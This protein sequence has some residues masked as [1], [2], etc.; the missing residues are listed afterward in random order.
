M[1]IVPPEFKTEDEKSEYLKKV[2]AQIE[3]QAGLNHPF[4]PYKIQACLI[5]TS[6][7]TGD[8]QRSNQ[9]IDQYDLTKKYQVQKV[10][11]DAPIE[12]STFKGRGRLEKEGRGL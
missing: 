1:K 6:L 3:V 7:I 12:D 5:E 9:L 4:S 11:V 8:H 2:K 10:E